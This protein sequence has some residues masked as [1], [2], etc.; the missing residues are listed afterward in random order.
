MAKT[1]A[2]PANS[3]VRPSDRRG[4][5]PSVRSD[6]AGGHILPHV[7]KSPLTNEKL[8]RRPDDGDLSFQRGNAQPS[9]FGLPAA[10]RRR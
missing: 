7:A 8:V 5:S 10:D 1:V 9:D 3:D 4:E 2:S 6:R